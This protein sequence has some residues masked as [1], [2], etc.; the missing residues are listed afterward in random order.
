MNIRTALTVI[1][2]GLTV[3]AAQATQPKQI[4][5]SKQTLMLEQRTG[6]LAHHPAVKDGDTGHALYFEGELYFENGES[7]GRLYGSTISIDVTNDG[8]DPEVRHRDLIFVLGDSQIISTGISGYPDSAKWK[9]HGQEWHAL[10]LAI[11][12]GTGQYIGVFGS[13]K[14]KKLKDNRFEH[15]LQMYRPDLK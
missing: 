10:D 12:G 5:Y 7:A 3:S 14:T 6:V 13:I 1:C 15:E 11:V 4:T 2:V 9:V 8:K